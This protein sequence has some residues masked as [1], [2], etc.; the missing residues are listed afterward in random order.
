M[1]ESSPDCV[2]FRF[3]HPKLLEIVIE[4]LYVHGSTCAP[5]EDDLFDC[6][7]CAFDVRLLVVTGG[8]AGELEDLDLPR[9]CMR[10]TREGYEGGQRWSPPDFESPGG[11]CSFFQYY[12][13]CL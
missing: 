13:E 3:D 10:A 11:S 4:R 7:S 9:C 12:V 8:V 5:H 2:S 6:P 1:H